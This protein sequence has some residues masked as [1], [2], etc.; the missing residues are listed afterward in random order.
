MATL[1][2]AAYGYGIRYEFGIFNQKI[3]NGWQVGV[4]FSFHSLVALGHTRKSPGAVG[5][6]S[7]LPAPPGRLH[8]GPWQSGGGGAGAEGPGRS[9]ICVPSP[10]PAGPVAHAFSLHMASVL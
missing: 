4:V 6:A 7:G 10:Q 2:L 1:G 9:V 5:S 8:S 3:V